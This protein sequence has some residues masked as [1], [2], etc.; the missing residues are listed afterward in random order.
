MMRLLKIEFRKIGGYKPFWILMGLYTFFL[1]C[2][3]YFLENF[4]FDNANVNGQ[5]MDFGGF[6]IYEFP[7]IWRIMAYTGSWWLIFPGI[8]VIMLITNEV[9][10]RTL[11]QGIINGL[12][13]VEFLVGQLTNILL[14]SLYCL[15][16]LLAVGLMMGLTHSVDTSFEA[17]SGNMNYMF[18]SFLQTFRY[19]ILALLAGLFF[20]KAGIAIA[21]L[22][23]YT[24][25]IGP[26]MGW[27]LS[28]SPLYFLVPLEACWDLVQNPL[29]DFGEMFGMGEGQ[30]TVEIKNVLSTL[31]HAA[32]DIGLIFLILKKRDL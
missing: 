29:W 16:V 25:I 9:G 14:I 7:F 26:I 21:V 5:Q 19:L 30:K 13:R 20:R 8:V 17:I 32:F 27:M 11:R 18:A 4:S 22:M 28:D 31:G 1:G 12:S 24:F 10:F 23:L 2:V 3:V 6:D 15:V